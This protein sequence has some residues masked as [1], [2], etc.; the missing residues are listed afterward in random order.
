MTAGFIIATWAVLLTLFLIA[1]K[2]WAD[3]M[4]RMD[5]ERVAAMVKAGHFD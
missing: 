5:N 3:R 4:E 1:N 2:R